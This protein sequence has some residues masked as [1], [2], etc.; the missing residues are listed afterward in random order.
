MTAAKNKTAASTNPGPYRSP[1]AAAFCAAAAA[2][3]RARASSARAAARSSLSSASRAL[4]SRLLICI[5]YCLVTFFVAF[6][7]ILYIISA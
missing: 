5:V 1:N 3:L 4:H 2:A 6:L 7:D